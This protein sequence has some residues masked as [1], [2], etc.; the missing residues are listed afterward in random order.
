MYVGLN[1]FT[2][3]SYSKNRMGVL[4]TYCKFDYNY[5][6]GRPITWSAG[7]MLYQ[8]FFL[9]FFLLARSRRQC[10][11]L[12]SNLYSRVTLL[13]NLKFPWVTLNGRFTQKLRIFDRCIAFLIARSRRCCT[14][15]S[16]SVYRAI[17]YSPV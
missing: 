11:G 12:S 5:D 9:Y 7:I 6:Y 16:S 2:F 8:C 4:W 10:I 13:S 15:V 17:A 1:S 3:T 14:V